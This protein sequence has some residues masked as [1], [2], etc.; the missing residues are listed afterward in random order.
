MSH[1]ED[2]ERQD[3]KAAQNKTQSLLKMLFSSSLAA[4]SQ[5]LLVSTAPL[6][7]KRSVNGPVIAS[8]FP[9]PSFIQVGSQYF[10]FSTSGGG[11]NIPVATS[12]DFNSWSLTDGDALPVVG[13]WSNGANVW[14]PDVVQL[15]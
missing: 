15:V 12:S 14:A 13:A 2:W 4:L 3:L 11:K 8:N 7:N 9:D 1:L 10:A 6:I 5:L